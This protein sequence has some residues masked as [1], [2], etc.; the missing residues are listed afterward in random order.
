MCKNMKHKYTYNKK[1]IHI[2]KPV[3]NFIVILSSFHNI[4]KLTSLGKSQ[5]R[6]PL[7]RHFLGS[8]EDVG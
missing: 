4:L 3:L 7:G 1:Y 8:C 5:G 6:H 2:N